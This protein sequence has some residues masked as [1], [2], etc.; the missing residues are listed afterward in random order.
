MAEP[1]APLSPFN[2]LCEVI[3]QAHSAAFNQHIN[4]RYGPGQFIES[5]PEH[6]RAGLRKLTSDDLASI[7]VDPWEIGGS[8]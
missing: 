5:R 4:R 1:K 2:A 6:I 3:S 8:H 7:R